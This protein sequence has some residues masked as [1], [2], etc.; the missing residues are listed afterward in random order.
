MTKWISV[1][2]KP[3]KGGEY[4]V[5]YDLKDGGYPLTTLM[6]F[7]GIKKIWT[8]PQGTGKEEK[9]VLYWTHL[10]K[11]PKNIPGFTKLII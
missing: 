6:L 7:D 11:P 10:P 9:T 5:T 8:D 2:I 3:K 1:K 4:I